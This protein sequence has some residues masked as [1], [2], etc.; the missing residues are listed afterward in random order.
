MLSSKVSPL[1]AADDVKASLLSVLSA[2][3]ITRAFY[4]FI[5]EPTFGIALTSLDVSDGFLV[6]RFGEG[7][8]EEPLFL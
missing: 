6:L 4:R 8:L 2:S 1:F 7:F 5:D 3:G